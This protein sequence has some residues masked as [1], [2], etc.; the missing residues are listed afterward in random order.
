M[1][2]RISVVSVWLLA[3][4]FLIGC[5]GKVGS[6]EVSTNAYDGAASLA[7]TIDEGGEGSSDDADQQEPGLPNHR[8]AIYLPNGVRVF[9]LNGPYEQIRIRQRVCQHPGAPEAELKI[10]AKQ[11]GQT[12]ATLVDTLSIDHP[13]DC[14]P[15]TVMAP[16]LTAELFFDAVPQNNNFNANKTGNNN[17]TGATQFKAQDKGAGCTGQCPPGEGDPTFMPIGICAAVAM[18][19]SNPGLDYPLLVEDKDN[20]VP[21]NAGGN[22]I[23]ID[24]KSNPALTLTYHAPNLINSVPLK[25]SAPLNLSSP[26]LVVKVLWPGVIT[27]GMARIRT[28]FLKT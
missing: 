15:V 11:F 28:T 8:P 3:L 16:P 24:A 2:T 6:N 5:Q 20:A 22:Y 14:R 4:T 25:K 9:L 10:W 19:F 1:K 7:S 13:G 21:R 18:K 27:A 23:A 17:L 12:D 26:T